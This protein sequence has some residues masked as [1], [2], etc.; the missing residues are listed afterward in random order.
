MSLQTTTQHTLPG[1][2]LSVSMSDRSGKP[3]WAGATTFGY[4]VIRQIEM[5]TNPSLQVEFVLF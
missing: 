4:V 3:T 5:A 1:R 2:P